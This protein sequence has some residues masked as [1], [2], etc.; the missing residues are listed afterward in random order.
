MEND[1]SAVWTGQANALDPSSEQYQSDT[2]LGD[3]ETLQPV[4]VKLEPSVS[5]PPEVTGTEIRDDSEDEESD[6]YNPSSVWS[7][8]VL[9][10]SMRE[11]R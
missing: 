3:W 6:M 10:R 2:A 8:G 4:K 11:G 7:N 9:S 5:P 1:T